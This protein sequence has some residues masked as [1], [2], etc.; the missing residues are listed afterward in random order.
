MMHVK[1]ILVIAVTVGL[2]VTSCGDD[3]EP[4]SKAEFVEQADAICQTTNDQAE[5]VFDAAFADIDDPDD[6]ATQ[7]L[8]IDTFAQAMDE[9]M[10]LYEQQ[11][12]DL[13][14]LDAPTED[15]EL[16]ETLLAD[17]DD[18]LSEYSDVIDAALAGD[19]QARTSL[20]G[21]VDP[22]SDVNRQAREYGMTVCGAEE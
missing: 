2:F 22:F 13:A 15:K 3:T 7:D 16:I 4:L 9:L 19:E 20:L 17:F 11:L 12:D 5:P 1:P 18:A 6:P 10:P 14:A 21:D 8:M